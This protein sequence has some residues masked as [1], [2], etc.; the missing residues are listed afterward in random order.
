MSHPSIEDIVSG[1]ATAHVGRCDT[2]RKLAEL[3]GVTVE[4]TDDITN[5]V[6]DRNYTDWTK[7]ADARGGMGQI[8]RVRDRRLDR[9][10][11]IKQMRGGGVSRE[12]F[13]QEA[14]LTARLQH[15]SIVGVYEAGRFADGEPFYAMPLLAGQP[16]TAKIAAATDRLALV[17]NVTAIAEALAYAHG[18]GIVHRDVKPDNILVGNFGE[19]VLID[20]GL[21]KD[22]A[23][24]TADGEGAYRSP[25]A[26]D[27]LTQLGVGTAHYM[28]PEQARGE[29]PDVRMDVYALGAT[30]YHV[31]AGTPPFQGDGSTAVR[32]SLT[33][34]DRPDP[35]GDDVPRELADIV[36]KAMSR[37]VAD[38]FASAKDLADELT[39]WQTGQLLTSRRYTPAELF[40]HWLRRHRTAVRISAIAAVALLAIAVI[41]F[42]RI[43]RERDAADR[44]RDNASRER[45]N[46]SRERD[47][48]ETELRRANATVASRSAADPMKRLDALELAATAVGNGEPV[49]EV[50]QGLVDVLAAGP[51]VMP[52]AH[53]GVIK[54][55]AVASTLL[56]VDDSR[57]LVVWDPTSGKLVAHWPLALP[58]PERAVPDHTQRVIVCGWDPMAEI[59]NIETGDHEIIEAKANIEGCG[60]LADDRLITAADR[61]EIRGVSNPPHDGDS[62]K[63]VP[64]IADSI[65][66]LVTYPLP[67]PASGMAIGKTHV[68][69]ATTDGSLWIWDQASHEAKT[70]ATHVPLGP[71]LAFE[72]DD[73]AVIDNGN[74]QVVRRFALADPSHPT[75]VYRDTTTH[76]WTLATEA[77]RLV[78]GM[79]DRDDVKHSVFR[80]PDHSREVDGMFI[81]WLAH[82]WALVSRSDDTI[83]VVDPTTG[84]TALALDG[85]KGETYAVTFDAI[86]N[87]LATNSHDGAAFLWDLEDPFVLGHTSE[88]THIF[89]GR[90]G[91]VVTASHDGSVRRWNGNYREEH[92]DQH[93]Q[94]ITAAA[95]VGGDVVSGD[96]GGTITV[97]RDT[98]ESA[99]LRG[100][101][102]ALAVDDTSQIIAGTSSGE[103]RISDGDLQHERIL[104]ASGP[105]VSAIAANSRDLAVGFVDGSIR[106]YGADDKPRMTRPDP[107]PVDEPGDHEGASSLAWLDDHLL[108]SRPGGPVEV[109]S[110]A[111]LKTTAT[112]DGRLLA[113][114]GT[115]IATAL[116]D[117]SVIVVDHVPTEAIT[118]TSPHIH[119]L[120][121]ARV[122]AQ[123]GAFAGQLFAFGGTDGIVHIFDLAVDGEVL[124]IPGPGLGAV[125]AIAWLHDYVVI[126]YASGATRLRPTTARTAM[127]TACRI[128]ARFGRGCPRP[129]P[130]HLLRQPQPPEPSLGRT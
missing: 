47:R 23:D 49:Q 113:T 20:W 92:R 129:K 99:T 52:L 53:S 60:W 102:S 32:K 119:H 75:E 84:G 57:E 97:V 55:F 56:G 81:A 45:D 72:A 50:T 128:L 101:I 116:G 80:A 78:I 10:V 30:L 43:S 105:A 29:S 103:L 68:A 16:L 63:P 89:V 120:V 41:A 26:S 34:G 22:L 76:L 5:R 83:A 125:T 36:D 117:G 66:N 130:N 46:A 109:L 25:P 93:A 85:H 69:V 67:S 118:A 27:G 100:S 17:P 96:L 126:G 11:A 13:E 114:A 79:A 106:I 1:T 42:V 87:R 3:A 18:E 62:P 98:T 112:I 31:L 64:S 90:D 9:Y 58:Q 107:F 12:R 70:I 38:R 104:E 71:T 94:P 65:A 111:D 54:H 88:I 6:D 44:E 7:L 91:S 15:P 59:Y 37:D 127:D 2:C 86:S 73:V 108:A 95:A 35:L 82:T 48:A 4:A 115:Q 122:P 39:R 124:S 121:G 123:V 40:R 19:T 61:V 110:R 24:Q 77:S 21:A 8:F 28:P 14:K 33:E 51:P 74:D